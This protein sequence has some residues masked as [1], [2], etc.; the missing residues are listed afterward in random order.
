MGMLGDVLVP[1]FLP[2]DGLKVS[3]C[4]KWNIS[5]LWQSEHGKVLL[6]LSLIHPHCFWPFVMVLVLVLVVSRNPN[7]SFSS[8]RDSS[9]YLQAKW[10]WGLFTSNNY[11]LHFVTKNTE[12]NLDIMDIESV[13]WNRVHSRRVRCIL[14]H[15]WFGHL[16]FHPHDWQGFKC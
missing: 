3:V 4:F 5:R 16:R 12:V 13:A 11:R 8:L 14:P 10:C 1:Q 2:Q 9:D 15:C 6:P 7:K